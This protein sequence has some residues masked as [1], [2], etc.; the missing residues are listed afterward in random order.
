MKLERRIEADTERKTGKEAVSELSGL[1]V[2]DELEI[3]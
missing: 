2:A 1:E 3:G